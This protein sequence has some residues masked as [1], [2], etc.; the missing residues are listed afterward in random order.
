MDVIVLSRAEMHEQ[1]NSLRESTRATTKRCVW[2]T[3]TNVQTSYYDEVTSI[4]EVE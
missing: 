2:N 4:A 1:Y 3:F